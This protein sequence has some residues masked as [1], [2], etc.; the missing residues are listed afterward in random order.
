MILQ[1]VNSLTSVSR[2]ES[3]VQAPALAI[4]IPWTSGQTLRAYW[5]EAELTAHHP[6]QQRHLAVPLVVLAAAGA[7]QLHVLAAVVPV[8]AGGSGAVAAVVRVLVPAVLP[9]AVLN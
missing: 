1:K 5:S 6:R 8:L 7:Q 9:S 2:R 4:L 3:V